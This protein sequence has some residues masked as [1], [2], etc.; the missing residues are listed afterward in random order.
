MEQEGEE[1][2]YLDEGFDKVDTNFV[3]VKT[4]YGKCGAPFSSKS[5]LYRH[6]KDGC[7]SS[8]Q[9]LLHGAPFSTSPI[10]IIT[11]RSVIIALDLGLAFQGWT[12]ATMAV[13]LVLRVLSF[14]SDL[15]STTCLDMGYDVTFVDKDWLLR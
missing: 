2:Q 3:G 15:G 13:T 6:L 4:S 12:Y 8:F 11:S 10:S 7:V 14:E 5:R 1:V 9:H